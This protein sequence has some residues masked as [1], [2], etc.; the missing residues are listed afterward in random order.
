MSQGSS[1]GGLREVIGRALVDS[2][3]R[4]ALYND[5]DNALQGYTL[6]DDERATLDGIDKAALDNAAMTMGG[7]ATT[8]FIFLQPPPPQGY[9]NP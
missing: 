2:D 9:N 8:N 1:Q 7:A 4:E 6:S 5:R 3:Y